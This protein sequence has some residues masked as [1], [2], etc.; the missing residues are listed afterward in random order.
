VSAKAV[1]IAEGDKTQSWGVELGK[2]ARVGGLG[3]V[4]L[5][6]V[7]GLIYFARAA[8]EEARRVTP[9]VAVDAPDRWTGTEARS[10]WAAQDKT[11]GELLRAVQALN[12]RLEAHEGEAW[13]DGAGEALAALKAHQEDT[14]RRLTRIESK[15]DALGR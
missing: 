9:V 4:A 15:I 5:L 3:I 11:N 14:Q 2:A 12:A 8:L 6:L 13:H 1:T 7:G 10:R